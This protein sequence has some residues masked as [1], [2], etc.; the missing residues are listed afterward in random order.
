[1]F[2]NDKRFDIDLVKGQAAENTMANILL[3]EAGGKVEVKS[4]RL[5]WNTT[6]NVAIEYRYRG[7]PSGI[8]TTEADFWALMF[9]A[10]DE[11]LVFSLVIAVGVLKT[12]CRTYYKDLARHK[13]GGDD[14]QSMM[15]LIPIVD[16]VKQLQKW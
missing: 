16:L 2:N 7:K 9:Y 14:R 15:L 4:E 5:H 11:A 10:D 3:A 1:M 6:G 8:A 13:A 12:I